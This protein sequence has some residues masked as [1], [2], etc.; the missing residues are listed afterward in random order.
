MCSY[1]LLRFP[2]TLMLAK[3]LGEYFASL[4]HPSEALILETKFWASMVA[5]LYIILSY[6]TVTYIVLHY[7]LTTQH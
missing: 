3:S 7:I 1:P 5:Q 2:A 4:H 6:N